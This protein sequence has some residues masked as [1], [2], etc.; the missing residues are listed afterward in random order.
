M[1]KLTL[2][3]H[4]ISALLISAGFASIFAGCGNDNNGRTGE[5]AGTAATSGKQID[6]LA[7]PAINEGLI[8][9]DGLL[10]A[11]NSIPPSAD[12]SD[13]A[14]PVRAQAVASLKAFGALGQSLGTTPAP[15]PEVIAGAFFPDVMR[16]DTRL[17]IPPGTP[18]YN[19]GTSG[20][21][22]ILT[23]GRKIPD[24]VIDITL[25]FLVAGDA[26]GKTVMDNVN[27]WGV[28][29]NPNQPGHQNLN[30]QTDRNGP[31]TFPFLATPN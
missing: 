9:S 11:F 21:L 8:I 2:K 18:A 30:G 19:A 26:T 4:S 27:Y 3:A 15:A 31:A 12:L 28:E 16:I 20:S 24:D 14:A 6:R 23:G 1:K 5:Q 29:G 13:A 7:R 22:G 17:R 25:S 10:N